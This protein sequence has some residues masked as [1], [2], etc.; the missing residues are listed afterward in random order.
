[1]ILQVVVLLTIAYWLVHFLWKRSCDPDNFAIPYLTA[2]G[3]L[4]GTGLLAIVW[5]ILWHIGD[6]DEDVGD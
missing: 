3:D 6:K 2:I 1:M 4:L 5:L